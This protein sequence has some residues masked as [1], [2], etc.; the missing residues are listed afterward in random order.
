LKPD[1]GAWV[2]LLS[3][4]Q[5]VTRRKI[6]IAVAHLAN[7]RLALDQPAAMGHQPGEGHSSK[8]PLP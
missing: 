8:D 2:A 4:D 5:P 1:A 7:A 6:N 3:R